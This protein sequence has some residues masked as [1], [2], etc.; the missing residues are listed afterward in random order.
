MIIS[1]IIVNIFVIIKVKNWESFVLVINSML[2][3]VISIMIMVF[4]FGWLSSNIVS[5]LNIMIG[6]K[7]LL[8]KVCCILLCLCIR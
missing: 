7:K 2:N 5:V 8:K 6:F 4:K 1:V 3:S